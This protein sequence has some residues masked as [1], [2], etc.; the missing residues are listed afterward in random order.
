MSIEQFVDMCISN[1][2]SISLN[3]EGNLRITKKDETPHELIEEITKNK[4]A[5]VNW[6][7]VKSQI[8][9]NRVSSIEPIKRD[10]KYFPLSFPQE[11]LWFVDQLDASWQYNISA[12]LKLSGR[13]NEDAMQRALSSIVA[14]H[15]VLRTTFSEI[16]GTPFQTVNESSAFKLKR[17][18]LTS[19]KIEEIES[20]I[21]R[22]ATEDAFQIFDLE[23]DLMLRV[24]LI[25]ISDV[26][27]VLL[28]TTHHIASDGW[29]TSV[30][31]KEFTA[32]YESHATGKASNLPA[33]PIQ[34]ID[35]A[36]WQKDKTQEKILSDALVRSLD[37]LSGI[38]TLHALPLD[39]QRPAMQLFTGDTCRQVIDSKILESLNALCRA[40]GCT[41]FMLLQ[42]AF[43]LLIGR[44]SNESDVVIGSP[45]AGR[46]HLEVQPLIG[47]FV[48]NIVLR[49]KLVV[50]QS[51]LEYLAAA[52]VDSTAAL[53]DQALPFGM[54]VDAI[55]PE[56][57][58]SYSPICQIVFLLQNFESSN[59]TLTDFTVESK[60]RNTIKF[61]L[62]LSARESDEGLVLDWIYADGLF[63]SSTI[64]RMANSFHMLLES[65][66]E[67]P[68]TDI[69]RLR[70]VPEPELQNISNW[71]S[72]R[73]DESPAPFVHQ[74]I[75]EQSR[76]HPDA[77]AVKCKDSTITFKELNQ[78]SDRLAI[79]LREEGIAVGDKVGL[80]LH[81]SIEMII[82]ILG[83]LKT[84]AAY[85]PLEPTFPKKRLEW[86]TE[87]AKLEH[88][89][90]HSE[91]MRNVSLSG[92]DFTLM[93]DALLPSWLVEYG[94][95]ECETP[96]IMGTDL[97][98]VLYTSGSTGHPKG[99]MVEHSGVI[100]YLKFGIDAYEMERHDGAVLSTPLCFDATVTTLFLPLISG[101][102]LVLVPEEKDDAIE[103]LLYY[104]FDGDGN[105]L[106][107]LTPAHL[108]ILEVQLRKKNIS[109]D[110]R[111]TIV[112]GGEQFSLDSAIRWKS[113]LL[114]SSIFVNEYGP[115]ETVVG[116]STFRIEELADLNVST[117]CNAVPIGRPIDNTLLH[118]LNPSMEKCPIGVVGELYIGGAG[119]ARGYTN[120]ENLTN[121]KFVNFDI[122]SGGPVRLYRTGDLVRY[123]FG[124]NLEFIG[125]TDSQVKV[126]GY[127]IELGEIEARLNRENV[128]EKSFVTIQQS[129]NEKSLIAFVIVKGDAKT[130]WDDA[131]LVVQLRKT[132]RDSLPEYMVPEFVQ[133][134]DEFPLTVNGKIDVALLLSNIDRVAGEILQPE[135]EI[136]CRLSEIWRKL[137]KLS[138]I[139]VDQS[140]F[141]LGGHSLLAARMVSE[142]NHQFNCKLTLKNIFE[143]RSVREISLHIEF[144][145]TLKKKIDDNENGS[146][147]VGQEE[148]EW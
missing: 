8:S 48:N 4:N 94:D 1:G 41:L 118:V 140:F 145:T 113:N 47:F 134:V 99:I 14:R 95:Y 87:D 88:I 100:N 115:T 6:I 9:V 27:H 131:T 61:D 141:D 29:S 40:N 111:H 50:G 25:A 126:R 55:K 36:Y 65:I 53:S 2:V 57:S 71:S 43:G 16:D 90:I 31:L 19:M 135:T 120:L 26:A 109:R 121:E 97:I 45:T 146:E 81:R 49:N 136:E 107:K 105:W 80:C 124:G 22:L 11:R 84:G 137:L 114:P 38:P 12:V 102:Q 30:L 76:F 89:L 110:A 24:T 73:R 132:L 144:L 142:V 75:E 98:Y 66:V 117:R 28:F 51:F 83:I 96:K 35:Y 5:I 91:L 129:G 123:H 69:Y 33:L 37:R 68:E 34:Y 42:C 59:F 70:I 20:E 103:A 3:A 133:L 77:I 138:D 106:F 32:F 104:L 44:W 79:Y 39:F 58:L 15:E 52:R 128:V 78:R 82:G 18:D 85:V 13:L 7:K 101:K 143:M 125:R 139:S 10:R 23:K 92:I 119:L 17:I 127:R 60:R 148:V 147:M 112:V 62:E 130:N 93:D 74:L 54:L 64:L 116:C 122:G 56:R 63:T 67:A 21:E 72:G 108:D 86:I 46:T